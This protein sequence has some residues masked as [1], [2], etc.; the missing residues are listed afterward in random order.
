MEAFWN[1][2][3]LANFQPAD[4][5]FASKPEELANCLKKSV[6]TV[7][8]FVNQIKGTRDPLEELHK[9]QEHL[10]GS[11][12]NANLVGLYSSLWEQS[13]YKRGLSHPKTILLAYM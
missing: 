1:P 11:L 2:K 5:R 7:H 4:S 6:T 3:L 8:D 13:V 10:L 12:S 9:Y